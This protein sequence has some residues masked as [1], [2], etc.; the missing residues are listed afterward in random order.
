M[1]L[2]REYEEVGRHFILVISYRYPQEIRRGKAK[3]RRPPLRTRTAS[4]ARVPRCQPQRLLVQF[5]ITEH[6]WWWRVPASKLAGE[7]SPSLR[8]EPLRCVGSPLLK[9]GN[10]FHGAQN[11]R[12]PRPGHCGSGAE[13]A[14]RLGS[15]ALGIIGKA[16]EHSVQFPP[17]PDPPS[18]HREPS[19]TRNPCT[20]SEWSLRCIIWLALNARVP[21]AMPSLAGQAPR[22]P[23]H[24]LQVLRS[25]LGS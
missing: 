21:L 17:D 24:V 6:A 20:D 18:V 14:Q 19:R 16:A 13:R 4:S 11:G 9:P 10:R 15:A 25:H 3:Q 2:C 8:L 22:D 5:A 7:P 1:I 12:K 23:P